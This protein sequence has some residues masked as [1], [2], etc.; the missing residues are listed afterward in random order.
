LLALHG[1]IIRDEC[2]VENFADQLER[3]VTSALDAICPAKTRRVR[4]SRR[5]RPPLS[6]EATMAERRRLERR[7][8]ALGSYKRQRRISPMLPGH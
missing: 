8:I 7:W 5:R 3:V 1:Q 4:C 6:A 2:A